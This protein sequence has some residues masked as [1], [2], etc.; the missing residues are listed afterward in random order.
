MTNYDHDA[1]SKYFARLLNKAM[2]R[3]QGDPQK[4]LHWL[5]KRYK[6]LW[7]IVLTKKRLERADA[8]LDVREHVAKRIELQ[9]R[10]I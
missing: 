2:K 4:A 1:Y 10:A 6:A 3:G 7:R 9:K 5:E 8:Y